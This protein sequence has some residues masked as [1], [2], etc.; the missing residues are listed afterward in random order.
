MAELSLVL[1]A[2]VVLAVAL[3]AARV[4]GRAPA[5][6][7]ALVLASSFAVLLVL[8]L[9][10]IT[11][12]PRVVELPVASMPGL[13][14]QEDVVDVPVASATPQRTEV[15]PPPA[16]L[17]MPSVAVAARVTWAIGALLFLAP[18]VVGVWRLQRMHMCGGLSWLEGRA[19]V[20]AVA[21]QSGVVRTVDVFLHEALAAP[22]TC[23]FRRPAIGLPIDAP[24]WPEADLHHALVHEIE[25]V[26]RGDWPVHLLARVTCAFY[27]FHP[28]AWVAWRQFSLE[29]E[30][31]C[32]DA[33]LR[34]AE[35][36]AYAEQLV[37]LAR[38][39]SKQSAVPML[40]MADR[41]SL[42]TRVSAV[43]DSRCARGR[44]GMI[45]ASVIVT[46]AMTVTVAISPLQAV[47]SARPPQPSTS[48]PADPAFE[49]ASIRQN[50]STTTNGGTRPL[51][52]GFTATN[53]SLRTLIFAAYR[54]PNR[55][56]I[57]GPSWVDS[58][59]YD[60]AAKAPGNPSP[61]QVNAMLRSLLRDRFNLVVHHETRDVEIYALTVAR[62]G[63]RLGPRLQK[64]AVDCSDPAVR[65][66]LA[67]APFDPNA[68]P[69]CGLRIVPGRFVA[70]GAA[71]SSLAQGLV[72]ASGR[73]V[74]DRT[75]LAGAFDIELEWAPTPD[76]D[77]VSVFTA[78]QEQLGLKLESARAPLDVLVIDR[79]DPATP[80]DGAAVPAARTKPQ[81]PTATP[82]TAAAQVTD[83]AFEVA[84]VRHNRSGSTA[85]SSNSGKDR[86]SVTNQ[87]ALALIAQAYGVRRERLSGG[88]PW[89]DTDRFDIIAKAP[90]NTPDSQIPL[91]LRSLLAERF[92]LSVRTEV[93]D[94]P[95]YALVL[96][97]KDGR[98][99][100]NLKA[101]AECDANSSMLSGAGGPGSLPRIEPPG[102][103][104]A[105][106]MRSVSD[107]RGVF[108]NAG[109]RP[110]SDLARALDGRTDRVVVDR[111]GL[112]GTY[113][114]DLRFGRPGAGGAAPDSDLP[115]V[116]TA[117]QEQLGLKLEA[118]R[119]P[120]EFLVIDRLEHPTEN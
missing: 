19:L 16:S 65:A 14:L 55:Q 60:I 20:A 109:A 76:A 9:A 48:A 36:T 40:S 75:G 51:P 90:D 7:R 28:L 70:G 83:V 45:S 99:G 49:V 84:S 17:R 87:T 29:S 73:T 67:A 34:G 113:S 44:A 54:I 97:N 98:L 120:V 80:N 104:I 46:V 6:V 64:A 59:R 30:R 110:L 82:Q 101:S 21:G 61:D 79:A 38:R 31:A 4:A 15:T 56:I 71:V 86:L 112:R 103:R 53:V 39:I 77:G 91:M 68:R 119:G 94:Q 47:T 32:D 50:T 95:V 116:F 93:R 52:D 69:V 111:S 89:L 5:S 35:G 26:R 25:H 92:S 63:G 118:D 72:N 108:I 13:M 11:I 22:M 3:L 23:G 1:K 27:W 85:G 107:A 18:I 2:T 74:V 78:V 114:F 42:A 58:L 117:L 115:I 41:S 43:L 8:P 66:R 102:T 81:A 62:A 33:V 57:G 105:C 10:I 106:G 12:P 88:P 96:A 100:P 37:T 24:H